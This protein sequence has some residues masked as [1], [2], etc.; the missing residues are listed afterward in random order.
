MDWRKNRISIGA[1]AFFVLLALTL[2]AVSNRNRQPS[3]SGEIPSL[4]VDKDAIT[5]LEITRP[6]DERIVL[7]SVDGAWRV[8]DPVD[9]AADQG[10]VESAL[11]RLSDLRLTRIVASKPENYA[12]LQ[13]DD[14]NAVQAPAYS[15]Q[16]N[17]PVRAK[18]V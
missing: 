14:A 18:P 4:E 10:N 11:N 6:E 13:V 12:R 5:A 8:T 2:W 1:V 3:G 16:K 7:S 9:A 17:L 15:Q